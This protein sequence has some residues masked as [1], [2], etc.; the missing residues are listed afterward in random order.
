MLT[1]SPGVLK[2]FEKHQQKQPAALEAGGQLFARLSSEEV[3]I[4]KATGPRPSDF[5]AR[6]LYVPD[7]VT[8][9]PEINHWHKKGLHYVGDW[10]THREAMPRPSNSDRES[11]RESFI[12]S[13]HILRGFVLIVVMD[14]AS[15]FRAG[16]V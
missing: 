14:Y 3:V 10:H 12:R 1:I 9:Q 13:T 2:H 8:E 11:I 7:R 15:R 4:E 6:A 16:V 5:R